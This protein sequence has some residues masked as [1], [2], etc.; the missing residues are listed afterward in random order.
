[1]VSTSTLMG[2]DPVD[3]LSPKNCPECGSTRLIVALNG[4]ATFSG[5][6]TLSV[7]ATLT[8]DGVVSPQRP[9]D[10]CTRPPPR[11]P[12]PTSASCG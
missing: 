8:A 1:M 7:G 3:P 2:G 10:G 6:G 12:L 4:G 5:S 9:V 11:A